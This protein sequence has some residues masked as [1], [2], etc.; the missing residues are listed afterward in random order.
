MTAPS[1]P[2]AKPVAATDAAPRNADQWQRLWFALQTTPWNSVAVV[3]VDGAKAV[4]V[5]NAIQSVGQR[6]SRAPVKLV[7]AA[8]L[9]MRDAIAVVDAI[10]AAAEQ[11]ALVITPCDSPLLNPASIPVLE[12]VDGVVL[13]VELGGPTMDVLKR[14]LDAIG[15]HKVR[16]TVTIG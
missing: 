4:P 10:T 8:G 16:A 13:V 12:A 9:P 1:E 5:A 7:S 11:Q 15:H 6:A 14:T 3:C 2:A